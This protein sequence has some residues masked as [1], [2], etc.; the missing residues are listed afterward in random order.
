MTKQEIVARLADE[1][2]VTRTATEKVLTSLQDLVVER[3]KDGQDTRL[4]GFGTFKA[5]L[6]KA[7]TAR[8][9]HNNQP[10]H[11]PARTALCFEPASNL[12]S[13]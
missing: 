13:L 2:G 4:H 10:V 5:K 8:N 1:A 7:R 3:A 6:K 11:V 9:P 12:K